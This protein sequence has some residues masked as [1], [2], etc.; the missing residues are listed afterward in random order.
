VVETELGSAT[1]TIEREAALAMVVRHSLGS[2]RLSLGADKAYD[3]HEF[4]DDLRG[5]KLRRTSPRT[6]P[7]A[8]RRS[9]P[10]RRAIPATPSVSRSASAPRSRSAR[11]RRSA[12]S[13]GRWR[14][15]AARSRFKFTL[16][17]VAY[18]P[19]R[20]PKIAGRVPMTSGKIN[21]PR[22]SGRL[23]R[24]ISQSPMSSTRLRVETPMHES[25][26]YRARIPAA[27]ITARYTRSSRQR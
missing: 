3:A 11:P 22:Q 8:A 24:S 20:P 2:Q 23:S 25:Q 17:M 19:I 15:G 18:D 14:R 27:L 21:R 12:G 13:P 16:A 6:P 10:A 5:L 4:V 9:A 7:T 1:G 26:S